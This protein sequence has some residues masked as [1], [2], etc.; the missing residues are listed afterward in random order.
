[1]TATSI[2]ALLEPIQARLDAAT[3]AAP[4]PWQAVGTGVRGGDHWYVCAEGQSI[5]SIACNDG[6]NE[7]QREP[8][9]RFM[10]AAPTDT[11]RLLAAV[12]AVTAL[13][14]EDYCC[15]KGCP[16]FGLATCGK[17]HKNGDECDGSECSCF[18]SGPLRAIESALRDEA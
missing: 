15:T 1:M 8:L 2:P 13:P 3:D 18:M 7:E 4:A 5:A 16:G 14:H 10:T 11:A 12:K 9:A 6:E 17:V